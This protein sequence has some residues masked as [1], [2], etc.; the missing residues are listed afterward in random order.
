MASALKPCLGMLD[1]LREIAQRWRAQGRIGIR[2]PEPDSAGLK[3]AGQY[4]K[5]TSAM[6]NRRRRAR[7]KKMGLTTMGTPFKRRPNQPKS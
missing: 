5:T 1:E 2:K 6:S 4:S 3:L 7:F